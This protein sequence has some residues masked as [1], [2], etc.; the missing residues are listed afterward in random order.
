MR[1]VLPSVFVVTLFGCGAA[2]SRSATAPLSEARESYR[3]GGL[4]ISVPAGATKSYDDEG[5]MSLR[6]KGRRALLQLPSDRPSNEATPIVYDADSVPSGPAPTEGAPHA[7]DPKAQRRVLE[8]LI[9]KKLAAQCEFLKEQHADATWYTCELV[10]SN[11]GHG[12][13]LIGVGDDALC[14]TACASRDDDPQAGALCA[15]VAPTR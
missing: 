6:W 3:C 8:R 13:V 9:E 5:H 15:S 14:T 2:P 4:A 10:S 7:K 11:G 1:A 12:R